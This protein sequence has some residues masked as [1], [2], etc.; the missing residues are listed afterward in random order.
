MDQFAAERYAQELYIR[1][2]S[3]LRNQIL[4]PQLLPSTP[5]PSELTRMK[6][7]TPACHVCHPIGMTCTPL[8]ARSTARQR[9]GA[10]L[11]YISLSISVPVKFELIIALERE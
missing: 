4:F 1:Y 7:A 11:F 5:Q 3:G 8:I 6:T 2:V 9:P 10:L